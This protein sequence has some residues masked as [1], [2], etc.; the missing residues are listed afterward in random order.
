MAHINSKARKTFTNTPNYD[1][2]R[3]NLAVL[4]AVVIFAITIIIIVF[5]AYFVMVFVVAAFASYK[6]NITV[7]VAFTM[8][9]D[10]TINF[11]KYLMA[12]GF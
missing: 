2:E 5:F 11:A 6:C 8:P 4:H 3:A 10:S 9:S 12:L 7:M 1:C